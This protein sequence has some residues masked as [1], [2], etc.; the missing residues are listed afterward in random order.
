MREIKFRAWDKHWKIKKMLF[1]VLFGTDEGCVEATDITNAEIMQFTGLLDKNG[2]EIYEG[3]VIQWENYPRLAVIEYEEDYAGF[4]AVTAPIAGEQ[5]SCKID[6]ASDRDIEVIGN[7]YE[8]S[9]L[10]K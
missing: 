10:L 5:E 9:K 1:F 2:K 3:D 8:N 7:I 4:F 6:H